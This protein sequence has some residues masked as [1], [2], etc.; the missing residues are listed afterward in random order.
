MTFI[1]N[2]DIDRT[3]LLALD[4][5]DLANIC[6]TNQYFRLLCSEESL[7]KTKTLRR[8]GPYLGDITEIKKYMEEYSFQTWRS[9]YI[10]LI[11][12]LEG[13]YIGCYAPVA[14][15]K[16]IHLL[17]GDINKNT[18]WLLKDLNK[19]LGN[20]SIALE[21]K[22]L[23]TIDKKSLKIFIDE[24]LDDDMLNPNGI[25]E[26]LFNNKYYNLSNFAEPLLEYMLNRKDR[27][28]HPEYSYN[29]LL[30]TLLKHPH[31]QNGEGKLF[32][33]V[34]KDSRVD[35]NCLFYT[36]SCLNLNKFANLIF[37][38]PRVKLDN[39]KGAI[40]DS[41]R[42]VINQIDLIP[43]FEA[44]LNKGAP[45]LTVID[46]LNKTRDYNKRGFAILRDFVEEHS[47]KLGLIKHRPFPRY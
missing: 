44:F 41:I 40:D 14:H 30:G 22:T 25:F 31:T 9:Y 12:F 5:Y 29:E 37:F 21:N 33:M 8:F 28:I 7:W 24:S 19:F 18:K 46:M 3:I 11:D 2:K 39:I 13:K 36:N 43:L 16:D 26:N 32:K 38:D 42:H 20:E 10:S 4:D 17:D 15:R 1:G 6:K 45:L 47:L 35:P 23:D 34:L 27:R